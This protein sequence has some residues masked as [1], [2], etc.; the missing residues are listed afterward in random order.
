MSGKSIASFALNRKDIHLKLSTDQSR[1]FILWV[2]RAADK[3]GL[4]DQR[5]EPLII[6]LSRTEHREGL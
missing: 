2:A 3:L 1:C 5:L 6:S 4:H